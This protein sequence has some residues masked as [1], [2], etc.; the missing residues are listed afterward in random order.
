MNLD[1]TR[2][3]WRTLNTK[4]FRNYVSTIQD[5]QSD[6]PA[7]T[8]IS[9]R[10]LSQSFGLRRRYGL[11]FALLDEGH[12]LDPI[13]VEVFNESRVVVFAVLRP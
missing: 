2:Y 11:F 6:V 1:G 4:V 12:C 13:A 10:F 7:T 3:S 9:V 5:L 8:D